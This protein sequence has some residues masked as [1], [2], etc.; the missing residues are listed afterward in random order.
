MEK[1][2]IPPTISQATDKVVNSC[3]IAL[4]ERTSA[5]TADTRRRGL[6]QFFR[7]LVQEEE[8]IAESANPMT[9]VRPR[10]LDEKLVEPLPD[11]AIKALIQDTSGKD[12]ISVRDRAMIRM[13]LDNGGRLSEVA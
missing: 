12:F 9:K 4:Q 11:E 2:E 5:S 10:K 1:A 13:L 8:E 6:V 7:W 3:P